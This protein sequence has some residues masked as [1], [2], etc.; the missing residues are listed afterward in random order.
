M[1]NNFVNPAGDHGSNPSQ[2]GDTGN[3]MNS[4]RFG[5]H[6]AVLL[7]FSPKNRPPQVI[8]PNV[9]RFT[10][11]VA[12]DIVDDRDRR[13]LGFDQSTSTPSIDTAILPSGVGIPLD[14]NFINSR[15][16]FMLIIDQ[17]ASMYPGKASVPG[18]ARRL[19]ATGVFDTE[20]IAHYVEGTSRSAAINPNAVMMFTHTDIVILHGSISPNSYDMIPSLSNC[21]DTIPSV[22]GMVANTELYVGS[23]VNAY[24][25]VNLPTNTQEDLIYAPGAS[26]VKV[27][28][29]GS[30][31]I[32]V[33][34]KTA[35]QHMDSIINIIDSAVDANDPFAPKSTATNRLF[36]L[37]PL[38]GYKSTVEQMI[39]SMQSPKLFN[40][41]DTTKPMTLGYL[42]RLYPN[43]YVM[44]IRQ[45][46][47]SQ[48]GLRDPVVASR[49]TIMSSMI[50]TT[51]TAMASQCNLSSVVFRYDSSAGLNR[52]PSW[53]LFNSPT[54]L[55][56][57][58]QNGIRSCFNAFK[59]A[60][61]GGLFKTLKAHNGDF[62]LYVYYDIG[63][64]CL[65]DFQY[66]DDI[67]ESPGSFIETAGCLSGM[68]SPVIGTYDILRN[69][70][71]Q[72]HQ[73]IDRV[74][75]TLMDRNTTPGQMG[76]Y[77][78][79]EL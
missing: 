66:K 15:Y 45:N 19:V 42:D 50:S 7:I 37:P 35:R 55:A 53:Q 58:N 43:M 47:V 51:V 74:G 23:A 54:T 16:T 6:P 60:L 77:I 31:T 18:P 4:F 3:R 5:Q 73:L 62:S 61:E 34:E 70:G 22:T 57:Q 26:S 49:N 52:T 28:D 27:N 76:Q 65:V 38:D 2:L 40:G 10:D 13:I 64:G 56:P 67:P 59:R 20:P 44:P 69:N 11:Q 78:N 1:Y 24:N 41:I 12:Q 39:H 8:R 72:L 30:S 21:F 17:C 79:Y 25:S 33:N 46:P 75:M 48:W 68:Q 63:S 14:Y 9:Y 71:L 32:D 29:A 36:T